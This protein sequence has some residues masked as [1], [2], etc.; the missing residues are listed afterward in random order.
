MA[1]AS[2]RMARVWQ[3]ISGVHMALYSIVE[4][5]NRMARLWQEIG[6]AGRLRRTTA[7]ARVVAKECQLDLSIPIHSHLWLKYLKIFRV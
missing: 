3:G 7:C 5:G 4:Y 6:R 1:W 2:F